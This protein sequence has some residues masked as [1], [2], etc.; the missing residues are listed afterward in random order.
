[1]FQ[2]RLP[3]FA[4]AATVAVLLL[5]LLAACTTVPPPSGPP[6]SVAQAA[7]LE[8]QGDHAAAA[9]QY[10]ALAGQVSG[11]ESSDMLLRAAGEYLAA[12]QTGDA[13]RML[14]ALRPPLTAALSFEQQM[15]E[16]QLDLARGQA[17]QAWH[18]I[19]QAQ[20]PGAPQDALAY[21]ELKRR[22]AFAAARPA[23]AVRAE[24]DAERFLKTPDER[25]AA[26]ITLLEELRDASERGM[27][28]HPQAAEDSTVRGWLAL[29]GVVA[30]AARAPASAASLLEAWRV[31]FPGHP[32][33]TVLGSAPLGLSAAS[34]GAQPHIALLLPLTGEAASA[35][36]TVRDGFM[37]AYYVGSPSGRP[38]IRIYDTGALSVS[39]AVNQATADGADFI[40]GPLT[41]EAVL[42]AAD[43]RTPHP[44][45]LALNFL[46]PERQAPAGLYQFALSPEEEAREVA[47]RILADG[48]R[49]GIALAP[50]GDWGNRVL[51]AFKDELAAGGGTLLDTARFDPA[52]T[53]FAPVITDVLRID[54]SNDRLKRLESTLGAKL[55]FQP[56]RRDDIDFIFEASV[57]APTA[58]L[59]RTQ[60]KFYFAGDVPAYATSDS[61]QPDPNAN[62]DLDGLNFPDMP[63][64]LGGGLPDSVHAAAT[65]AW[66]VEGPSLDRLFAFGFDAYRLL[67]ALRT[68]PTGGA[69]N[70][71]GMSGSLTLD[72]SG[73]VRRQLE[74]AQLRGGQPHILVLP[75]P[76]QAPGST[77]AVGPAPVPAQGT[78]QGLAP[79]AAQGPAPAPAAAQGP[80]P[81]P[82]PAPH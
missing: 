39:E 34:A 19:A 77:S 22:V 58:R 75:A 51:A 15:L 42:A 43:L 30:Q 8:R 54:E 26:R 32:A 1:M 55:A 45:M 35:A 70:I 52:L 23:D 59:L 66:P 72:A 12:H 33:D 37:T 69:V 21:L 67:N 64:M 57:S 27:Q 11:T 6:P 48:H 18:Q 82:P 20:E 9:R 44:P 7:S 10:E 4:A 76:G 78:A 63:W 71:E 68:A 56:R 28:I 36:A 73:R 2:G 80:A 74:W 38:R 79:A 65:T 41:R 25:R 61:F 46:P 62:Q 50:L 31:G 16:A 49:H 29:A 81:A 53:D 13:A 5:A 14:A 40:V 47:R 17:G 3:L 24:M 60:L